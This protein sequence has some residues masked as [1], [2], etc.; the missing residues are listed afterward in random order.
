VLGLVLL[1]PVGVLAVVLAVSLALRPAAREALPGADH[2]LV[3]RAA[4]RTGACRWAGLALGAVAALVVASAGTLGRGP[5]LAPAVLG[6]GV[7]LG[8]LVGELAVRPRHGRVRS[9]SLAVRR[10]RDLVPRPTGLAVGVATA[11]LLALLVVTTAVASPD[12][13]GRTGRALAGSCT[14]TS[15]WSRTP[16]PGAFYSA[17]LAAAVLVGTGAAAAVLRRVAARPVVGGDGA[18]D[19]ADAVLRRRAGSALTAAVGVLVT[20]PLAGVLAVAAPVAAGHECPTPAF[21][22]LT[23]A[24]VLGLPVAVGLLAWCLAVLLVPGDTRRRV[25][26]PA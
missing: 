3:R 2:P 20:A 23:A 15:S 12:D 26:V 1:L 6:L 11:L 4:R 14:P 13:L 17:P 22:G 9:A 8:V 16:W 5:L 21:R 25:R 24:L 7:V 18:L 19:A 10:A